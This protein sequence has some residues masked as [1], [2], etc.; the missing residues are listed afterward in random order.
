MH[1]LRLIFLMVGLLSGGVQA[2]PQ[3]P[4]TLSNSVP[5]I[6]LGLHLE[7]L[8]DP[9]A[10]LTVSDVRSPAYTNKFSPSEKEN[11]E[12][13]YTHSNYWVRFAVRDVRTQ[14]AKKDNATVFLRL[15]YPQTDKASLW[16]FNAAGEEL[17]AQIAGDHVPRAQWPLPYPEP[18][19]LV[20]ETS[21]ECYLQVTGSG[22]SVR[23]P[24]EL[25]TQEVYQ[26]AHTATTTYQ[27]LYFGAI[28]AMIAYNAIL[29]IAVLSR[30]YAFYVLFL[31]SFGV[32]QAA[33]AGYGYAYLWPDSLNGSLFATPL[34]II[35]TMCF[36]LLFARSLLNLKAKLPRWYQY[37]QVLLVLFLAYFVMMW[38]LHYRWAILAAIILVPVWITG[39]IGASTR[40]AFQG[41]RLARIYLLAWSSFVFGAVLLFLARTGIIAS[42]PL[43]LN[44]LQIG[45]VLEFLLLSFALSD[46]IK[47]YQKE[48][49]L[50]KQALVET[51]QN[52]EKKLAR[53]VTE[54]T[55][56]LQSANAELLRTLTDLKD[57][58][59]QLIVAEKMAS[60]GVLV[61]NVAHEINTPMGAIKSSGSLIADTLDSCFSDLIPLVVA[62]DP[63]TRDL[64]LK[65]ITR[66]KEMQQT[67]SMREERLLAKHLTANLA[68]AGVPH[69]QKA[70]KLLLR[71]HI[72]D[73][74]LTYIPLLQHAQAEAILQASGSIANIVGGTHNI[75][76]CT[77]KVARMV[78]ALKAL[79]AENVIRFAIAAPLAPDLDKALAAY[80]NQLRSVELVKHYAPDMPPVFANHDAMQHL[81]MHLIHNALQA[82]HYSGTLTLSV[83]QDGRGNA[84]IAITDTGSGVA[85]DIR[86][87]MFEPF[88]TTRTSGE[89]SGLGLAI[90][91]RIAEQHRGRIT[92]E[93]ALDKG[94]TVTVIFPIHQP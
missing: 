75:N 1:L 39:L 87:R 21:T 91:R 63:P 48:S 45:S 54:R 28:I 58:Q 46:R 60:L 69:P 85:E 13:G 55:Q 59:G 81:C 84:A 53:K 20:A 23:F 32:F 34:A 57:T 31:A 10:K 80:S 36:A 77:E 83:Q 61:S 5:L 89:G 17:S 3:E 70:A 65:L 43:T 8:E 29:A 35:A 92:V 78:Y 25:Q 49:L 2:K 42:T 33:E 14:E 9:L 93:S 44:A 66:S 72:F 6:K 52:N 47:V 24:L 38:F 94:T 76:Q 68:Q 30:T 82:M 15:A 26:A 16:C 67:R 37:T 22:S 64:F 88:F 12:F 74:A 27:A 56:E 79:S 7:W 86:E 50:A 11:P 19:F 41:D 62:L 51:L 73:E 4:A 18:V 40:L 71:F 90:V